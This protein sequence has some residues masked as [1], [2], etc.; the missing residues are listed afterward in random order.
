MILR[1]QLLLIFTAS[2]LFACGGEKQ[3]E[4]EDDS[5]DYR[6][7]QALPPLIKNTSSKPA[8]QPAPV[9]PQSPVP[10][11]ATDNPLTVSVVSDG[12]RNSRLQINADFDR[13]WDMLSQR[14]KGSNITV[15]SRNRDAGRIAIGCAELDD[16]Q[17]RDSSGGWSILSKKPKKGLEY[18]ALQ[19]LAK[20]RNTEVKM[21][22]RNAQEVDKAAAEKVFSRLLRDNN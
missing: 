8:G 14:L 1:L 20:K 18:C 12:E 6:S 11:Q 10:D 3:V 19:V 16:E 5:A 4:T 2:V 21:L 17:P 7:A 22:N 15:H 13:S 9:I